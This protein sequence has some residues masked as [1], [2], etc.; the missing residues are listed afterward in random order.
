MSQSNQEGLFKESLS[1]YHLPAWFLERNVKTSSDLEGSVSICQ[2]QGCGNY[3]KLYEDE[4][5]EGQA[6][7]SES[8][9]DD[10]KPE[11]E[12]HTSTEKHDYNCEDAISYAKFSELRDMVATNMLWR[13]MRP[14]DSS[15]LLRRCAVSGCSTCP[16]EPVHMDEIVEQVAK[17]L[18][19]GLVLLSFEDLEELGSDFHTQDR[20][21]AVSGGVKKTAEEESTETKEKNPSKTEISAGE[22][23][24]TEAGS[25]KVV[26][27]NAKGT[28][29]EVT[30]PKEPIK[31]EWKANWSD[32]A[33]FT[34]H[35]F[36]AKS[37]KWQDEAN[38][39]YSAWRDRAKE[40]YAAILDG[41]LNKV[42]QGSKAQYESEGQDSVASNS[43]GLVVHFVDCDH[44]GSSLEY[45]Q[46]RRV[47]V[48]LGELVQER[49]EKGQD[50]VLVI[51]SRTLE[52]GE[53]LC[54]KA[55]VS[56]LSGVTLSIVNHSQQN[57]EK[58]DLQRKGAINTRRLRWILESGM[59]PPSSARPEIDW[60]QSATGGDLARYG[61]EMWSVN[62]I[63][64]AAGQILARAWIRPQPV[65]T[66]KHVDSVL[67]RLGL[68]KI[69]K[70]AEK[71]E[72]KED[73]GDPETKGDDAVEEA[74]KDPL[75]GIKLD[76]HEERFRD[77]AI[78]PRDLNV[79]WDDV[80]LDQD[81][82]EVIQNLVPSSKLEVEASS[83]FL[84]SQLRIRGCL[85]YG[86]PGTGK[87]HL[88]RAIASASGSRMLSIDYAT[89]QS[90][91]VG[92]AE[93][94]IRA[95][96]SLATKMHP[97][98][99]FID[100]ADALFYRRSS[101]ERSWERSATTQFLVEM[102]GLAR[103][104]NAPLVV[105]ATNRPWDL[106]E[107][108]LRRL[109]QKFCIGLP[110]RDSRAAILRLFL[111]DSDLDPAV[112]VDGIADATKGYS[113]SDLRSLCAEAALVWKIEQVKL[114][115]LCGGVS[116][117]LATAR[118]GP[119]RLRLDVDHF[120]AAFEKMQPSRARDT[121]DEL[122]RFSRRYNPVQG[123]L[124]KGNGGKRYVFNGARGKNEA[125]SVRE[126]IS[127]PAPPEEASPAN[128]QLVVWRSA[129]DVLF[130]GRATIETSE[131]SSPCPLVT[132]GAEAF[133]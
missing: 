33:T 111:K 7:G 108:F 118:G 35:F 88:C 14:Q 58:R 112:D 36:A 17:S 34:D 97:C 63:H 49:R 22:D 28:S 76:D 109:P 125:F 89:T 75:D 91:M 132:K 82:K 131:T 100:E 54:Q 84:L 71:T 44:S 24:T 115:A 59:A 52:P 18:G 30:T 56:T 110:G 10:P 126:L 42:G 57:S 123:E 1:R 61:Q 43:R 106:D 19:M 103:N 46:K 95:A 119:K 116:P 72:A 78:K 127:R 62:D 80:I 45:R 114:D 122:A 90:S 64:R 121:A 55:G 31:D 99:L 50:V 47:L 9:A 92:K 15:V 101:R 3:K 66:S 4:E 73:S 65:I 67:K 105:V 37:K 96:F 6:L 98:V 23:T 20:G 41:A 86:P 69:A 129:E 29:D 53:K 85:L 81:I 113:G 87:T 128:M 83:D 16:M 38:F 130:P 40:S 48:R 120:A 70:A 5:T 104:P 133:S 39:S 25:D 27:N 77:C 11:E 102:E 93:K 60:L 21:F 32:G 117:A 26:D 107:A 74:E 94:Y 2:C 8:T 124:G 13:H 51:S 79:S 12:S 68:L